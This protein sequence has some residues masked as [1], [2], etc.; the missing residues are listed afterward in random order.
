[1]RRALRRV[2]VLALVAR[3]NIAGE[4]PS[5]CPAFVSVAPRNRA[6]SGPQNLEEYLAATADPSVYKKSIRP[7]CGNST[8]AG[9]T[10]VEVQFRFTQLNKV[11]EKIGTVTLNGYFR[12]WWK[13]VRLAFNGTAQG[14][15][16]DSIELSGA[17]D[18]VVW[19]PDLYVDNLVDMEATGAAMTQLS[20]D[21]S[22]WYSQQ[23]LVTVKAHFD[24]SRLPFDQHTASLRVASYSQPSTNL[25]VTAKGGK[26]QK[27]ESGVGLVGPQMHDAVWHFKR[28]TST[29]YY[30][31]M[32]KV[33]WLDG[34]DYVGLQLHIARKSKYYEDQVIYPAIVFAGI[35]YA[36]FYIEPTAAPARAT[37]AVI[38]VL[39]MRTMFNSMYETLP[40]S[41][42]HMWLADFL[43][44]SNFLVALG[45][46]EFAIVMYCN[47]RQHKRVEKLKGLQAVQKTAEAL[48]RRCESEGQTLMQVVR[49]YAPEKQRMSA[50][51]NMRTMSMRARETDEFNTDGDAMSAMATTLSESNRLQRSNSYGPLAQAARRWS[52][53]AVPVPQPTTRRNANAAQVAATDEMGS[54][55]SE[56]SMGQAESAAVSQGPPHDP[57]QGYAFRVKSEHAKANGVREADLLFIE[58]AFNVFD[59]CSGA[60]RNEIDVNDFRKALGE[61]NIYF[62]GAHCAR[63]MGMFLRELGEATPL[64]ESTLTLSFSQFTMLLM[65]IDG[66]KLNNHRASWRTFSGI[67]A[68]WDSSSPAHHVDI[69]ARIFFP[70]LTFGQL[71]FFY[72]AIDWGWGAVKIPMP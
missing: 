14:G 70:M 30:Q 62:S 42:Q 28:S 58:Y 29:E 34:W 46:L 65:Q 43:F 19:K 9:P 33:E 41:S 37:V 69:L 5:S 26:F 38:P 63:V 39:I 27:G 61:F 49:Q 52:R 32:G 15:C 47:I 71:L 64:D 50:L 2:V 40:Q 54:L 35:S 20:P 55:E 36:Q 56:E 72:V 66:Y 51:T 59:Q 31:T 8:H 25:R 12:Q 11:D 4:G 44:C 6:C 22:V 53:V 57:A 16:F 13:D 60:I 3:W 48:L 10:L 23:V 24:L 1:M 17:Q 45:A 67:K 7:T 21:G 18:N 68:R